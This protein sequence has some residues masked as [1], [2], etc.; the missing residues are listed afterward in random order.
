MEIEEEGERNINSN[1]IIVYTPAAPQILEAP[2]G[3]ELKYRCTYASGEKVATGLCL[4][5]DTAFT[6]N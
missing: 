5:K 1:V 4:H 3:W 2:F 6:D